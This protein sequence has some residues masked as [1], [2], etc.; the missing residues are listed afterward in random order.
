MEI[1]NFYRIY[2]ILIFNLEKKY[3]YIDYINKYL[4]FLLFLNLINILLNIYFLKLFGE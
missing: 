2:I 1:D 3:I 4:I